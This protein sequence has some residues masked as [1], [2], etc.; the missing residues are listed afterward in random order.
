MSSGIATVLFLVGTIFG[1]LWL[2]S[3]SAKK[4]ERRFIGTGLSALD[5]FVRP[6][7]A[8]HRFIDEH[9][10]DLGEDGDGD[11]GDGDGE[12]PAKGGPPPLA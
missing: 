8:E 4:E 12:A 9:A 1:G 10:A 5:E 11:G 7:A 2:L 3:S 6:H